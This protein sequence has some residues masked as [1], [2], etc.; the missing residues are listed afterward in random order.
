MNIEIKDELI[1]QLKE[2]YKRK[3]NENIEDDEIEW[4]VNKFLEINLDNI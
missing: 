2:F 1:N 3:E 4:Y